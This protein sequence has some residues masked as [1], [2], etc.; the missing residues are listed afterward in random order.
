M[1]R[2]LRTIALA[3]AIAAGGLS[4]C[5]TTS[6]TGSGVVLRSAASTQS[7]GYPTPFG[8]VRGPGALMSSFMFDQLGYPDSTGLPKPWLAQSWTKSA[9]GRTWTF[10]LHPNAKWTD[11]VPL[12]SADVVFSFD[13][14]MTGSA[15]ATG[16]QNLNSGLV[17]VFKNIASVTASGPHTVVVQLKAY[18]A[19]FLSDI[20]SFSGL[21]IIPQHIW[22]SVTDPAH[23]QGPKALIGSGPYVLKTFDTTT[24][25]FDYVANDNFY[26]GKPAVKRLQIVQAANP[27][28]ALEQGQLSSASSGNSAVPASQQAA[29]KKSFTEL[30]APGE[31]N[32]ALFVNSGG[33]FPYDQVDFRHAVAYALNHQD[34]L[35]RLVGGLGIPG[36]AGGLGPSNSFLD[37]NVATYPFNPNMAEALL[38]QLGLKLPAGATYRTMPDGSALTIPLLSSASDIQQAQ[39]VQQYLRNV[40]LDSKID[41]VDQATSDASDA[42]GQYKMAIVHF[43]G[44][45]A[46]PSALVS[47]FASTSKSKSF[48]RVTGYV[49][50]TF[51]MLAAQQETTVDP[52]ARKQVV[53]QMQAIIATDL[54]ELPL[55]IPE[56]VSYVN[57]KVFNGWGYTPGCPPC[58][59]SMN[60][61]Q[62]VSGNTKAQ[63]S[64]S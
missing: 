29:L 53:F 41:S 6:S 63:T 13:Y 4:A 24:N 59:V 9:D 14:D 30:T 25:T 37:P 27:I 33:G 16:T 5:G 46:D 38:N 48:T 45:A 36:S 50:P 58:S 11:G 34:M 54:P 1:Y 19:A 3:T 20:T 35:T 61:R 51:D 44:L 64:G 22:S 12:T 2:R 49:N 39:L 28:L 43:G 40:G 57:T 7:G 26:L 21:A 62:L 56:Q 18:D 10:D 47:R 31:F 23:F 15:S 60:K 55:Y 42:A 17:Q 8:A 32:E 52:A